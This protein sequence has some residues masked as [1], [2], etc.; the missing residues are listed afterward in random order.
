VTDVSY[1]R[2]QSA[3]ASQSGAGGTRHPQSAQVQ[4]E[5]KERRPTGSQGADQQPG[6]QGA[7]RA[8]G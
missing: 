5:A 2:T 6:S 8:A 3:I 1:R 7:D 4:E